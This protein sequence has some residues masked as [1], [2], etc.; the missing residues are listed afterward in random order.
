MSGGVQQRCG[1]AR[2]LAIGPNVQSC[3]CI[4]LQM[5]Y[6]VKQRNFQML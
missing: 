2:S 3:V 6:E 1:L 4:V 5:H